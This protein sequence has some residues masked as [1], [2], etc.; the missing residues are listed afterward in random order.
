MLKKTYFFLF[1]FL[2]SCGANFEIHF[3]SQGFTQEDPAT[4]PPIE[5]TAS[6][7]AP[8]SE[9]ASTMESPPPESASPESTPPQNPAP[10]LTE[11]PQT[12]G[13]PETEQVPE[14]EISSTTNPAPEND[15]KKIVAEEEL[16]KP[17]NSKSTSKVKS[18][19]PSETKM[20]LQEAEKFKLKENFKNLTLNDVI[21]QGLRKNYD[22]E[23]RMQKAELNE[24]TFS[25]V[26][27]AFWLPQLKIALETNP[28]RILKI[29]NSTRPP[30]SPYGQSPSGA[31][32]LK[33][34][35]F[36]VFNWG[37][38]YALYLNKKE[39]Y[40]RNA[41]RFKEEKRELKLNLIENFFN[42]AAI[43]N[44]E[45]IWQDKLRQASFVYRLAKEKITIGKAKKQEFYQARSEY[46]KAQSEYHSA[47]MRS[48]QADETM[49]ITIADP[50]GTKYVINENL[51][52]KRI[53]LSLD[54]ALNQIDS[55]NPTIL[56]LNTKVK[57][58]ERSLDVA[59]KENLPLPKFT[60]GLGAYAH[61]FGSS[62]NSTRYETYSDSGNIELVATINAT[63]DLL[64]ADGVF[65]S[66]KLAIKRIEKE[67]TEKEIQKS[68][69]EI[70][71][72]VRQTYSNILSLQ[73]QIVILEARLQ[74][75]EKTFEAIKE[76]YLSGKSP[77]YDYVWS[78]NDLILAKETFVSIK[79]QHLKE[80]LTLAKLMGV[81]DFPGENFER[82]AQRIRGQ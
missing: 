14:T 44:Y 22:Q 38:D 2:L 35:D 16:L 32:S 54:E 3:L 49:A 62:T 19:S 9:E 50:I 34:G 21:E 43:K 17:K 48:D 28:Q 79:F 52:F 70:S 82:L 45:K 51:D 20:Y 68:R 11:E 56:S 59:R 69:H 27:S 39:T 41:T 74:G 67:L 58:S 63:W 53:K 65:N 15:P 24:I 42:L 78:L 77:F 23:L 10:V 26:K 76:N 61:R 25:G 8:V 31:L 47:K 1:L 66:N 60:V 12:L 81:E 33:L 64:G 37:K 40:E 29:K 57:I 13:V 80:K 36:T 46:L 75:H 30:T 5:D 18:T 6:D 4:G 55:A 71:S 73:N 72:L 7:G